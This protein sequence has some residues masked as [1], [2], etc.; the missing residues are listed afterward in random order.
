MTK[1]ILQTYDAQPSGYGGGYSIK[2]HLGGGNPL[3][4][5]PI[6]ARN[7]DDALA[8]LKDHAHH[9]E[10]LGK[11][12]AA[13]IMLARGERAPAGWRKLPQSATTIPVNLYAKNGA[14]A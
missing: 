12:V 1:F 6:E 4:D 5:M 14:A 11:P 8:Q 10:T 7:V 2:L 3:P 13:S 9:C